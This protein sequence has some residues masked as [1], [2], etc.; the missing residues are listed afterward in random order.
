MNLE[1]TITEINLILMALGKRPAEES[2]ELIIKILNK[3]KE[4]QKKPE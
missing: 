3:S 2:M 1:L 4:E